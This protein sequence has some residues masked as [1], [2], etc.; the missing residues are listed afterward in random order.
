MAVEGAAGTHYGVGIHGNSTTASILAVISGVNR[1]MMQ[2]KIDPDYDF[3][4][5]AANAKPFIPGTGGGG[6]TLDLPRG[7]G[8]RRVKA[9]CVV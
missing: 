3:E 6:S 5:N 1:A 8:G 2:G 4:A 9:P 7:I